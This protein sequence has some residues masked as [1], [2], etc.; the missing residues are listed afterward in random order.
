M[1]NIANGSIEN[2][3]AGPD[4]DNLYLWYYVIF[5][6]KDCPYEEGYY[7]G[8]IKIPQEYPLKPPRIEMITPNGRFKSRARI[9]MSM[10]DYHPETWNPVWN[11]QTVIMGLIS[12]FICD[13]LTS[14]CVVTTDD[15]KKQLASSSLEHN[16]KNEQKFEELFS[17]YYQFMGIKPDDDKIS[18]NASP[19]KPLSDYQATGI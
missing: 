10:S 6:L 7:L 3:V 5:G 1:K 12:F 11:I 13:E 15:M 2:F 19:P 9:C 16:M 14:G 17:K 4:G 18:N 8:T